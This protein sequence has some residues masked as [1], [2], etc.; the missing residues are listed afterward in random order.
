MAKRRKC[1]YCENEYYFHRWFQEGNVERNTCTD[2]L[3]GSIDIGAILE[4]IV[5]GEIVKAWDI[6][7]IVFKKEA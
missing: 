7:K 2:C 3:D 4:N 5:T 6:E 1:L